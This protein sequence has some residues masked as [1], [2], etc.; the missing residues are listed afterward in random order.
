[1]Q[2]LDAKTTLLHASCVSI[3]GNGVLICGSS[4]SGKSSLAINLIAL[5]AEL[6]A[7]DR[8]IVRMLVLI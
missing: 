2:L 6:V 7:D 8:T 3:N 4:G 5:G 1:M